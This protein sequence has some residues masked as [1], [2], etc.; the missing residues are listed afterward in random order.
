[1]KLN[2][3]KMLLQ[4]EDALGIPMRSEYDLLYRVPPGAIVH[5]TGIAADYGYHAFV[6][7][8]NTMTGEALVDF[9]PLNDL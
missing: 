6:A 3:V 9:M 5:V 7:I 4:I 8:E 2:F 1:M